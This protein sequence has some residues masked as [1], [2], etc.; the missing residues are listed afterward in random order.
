[1][2]GIAGYLS[3]SIAVTETIGT[4]MANRIQHRGP[5]GAGIWLDAE[6][7]V[8]LAHRRLAVV[9]LTDAGKQPMASVDGRW[10]LVFNGEIYNH[11]TLRKEVQAAGWTT[12]WR[13]HSD[14]E[15]LLAA[16]QL[17]GL[18]D[19]LTRLNGMFAIALWD[20]EDRSLFLARDRIG[21]KPLFYSAFGQSFAFGSELKAFKGCPDWHGE[22]DRH[23][24]S[25]YLRHGYVPDPHCIYHGVSKLAPGHWLC[26]KDGKASAPVPYWQLSEVTRA[27]VQDA[28][29][30]DIIDTLEGRLKT[31]VGLRMEADVPL[32]AFL[33]GGIDSSLVVAMMQSQSERPVQTFTIGFEVP[34]YNE[35]ENAKA[36]AV[37]LGT[38]HTELYLSPKDAMD[39]IPSLPQIWDEPFADSSQIPTLLLSKMTRE[40]VTVA[41]SGDGGDELFCGYNRY[42]QGYSLHRRLRGLPRPLRDGL[43][44]VLHSLPAHTIDRVIAAMPQNLRYPPVGDRLNKLGLVL[45]KT[46]GADF[47]RTLVSQFQDPSVIANGVSEA[48]SLLS[49]PDAWPAFD[50]FRATM[51]YLDMLT[52]LP[53]DILTKVDRASMAVSLEARVPLLDHTLIEYA[54]SLPLDVKVR[55]GKTKWALRQVLERH[56]P[57]ELIERPKMGFGIPIEHWL[58]GPLRDWAEAL[59]DEKQM[60]EEGYL[61]ST[62]VRALWD[63]YCGGRNR[64][65]Y[66][67]WTILMF[68]AW[69]RENHA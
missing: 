17:W 30:E 18:E 4:N 2:C 63:G 3:T 66:P 45:S 38:D 54:W 25:L 32:G 59:L 16:L 6:A 50:D 22:I 31:A 62:A 44:R 43:A 23:V 28:S 58:A 15:T 12:S 7:G 46:E 27:P 1:M 68:Q 49:N 8:V 56:V 41:L 9:D 20:Q 35:A 13:G 67:I 21:E 57:I 36:M 26:V 53:G 10:T 51:M 14:T 24:L 5:D 64:A 69:L 60:A 47:Y 40:H 52:Y 61:N 42:G 19:T 34:G 39:V 29:P 11:Q 33:S 65:H 37:H 48:P 55:N